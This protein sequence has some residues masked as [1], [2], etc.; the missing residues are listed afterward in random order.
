MVDLK[1]AYLQLRVSKSLWKY[2]LVRYKGRPYKVGVWIKLSSKNYVDNFKEDIG[3]DG[4]GKRH[5]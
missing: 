3:E 5:R 2:Q 1:S 4:K